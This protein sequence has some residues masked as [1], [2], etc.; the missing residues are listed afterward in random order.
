MRR[1]RVHRPDRF[2]RAHPRLEMLEDRTLLA[3]LTNA[4]ITAGQ[5]QALDDGLQTLATWGGTAGYYAE[6]AQPIPGLAPAGAAGGQGSIS[7]GQALD[8]RAPSVAGS[9][10]RS[11]PSSRSRTAPSRRPPTNW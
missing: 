3:G 7:I 6:L 5:L 4:T 9:A 10:T 11:T 1:P 2:P 8:V